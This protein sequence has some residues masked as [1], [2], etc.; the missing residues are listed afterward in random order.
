MVRENLTQSCVLP[1]TTDDGTLS[2]ASDR[3]NRGRS[4]LLHV[5]N[6]MTKSLTQ[7]R[8]WS[9]IKESLWLAIP[10]AIAQL[11]Q[12]ATAF[13]D[14]VMMGLLGS[15]II[16]AGALGATTFAMLLLIGSAIVSAVSPLVA[17]AF[18]AQ[19]P[20]RV[21][22][23]VRQGIWLALGLG[24]PVTLL[25]WNA[26]PILL[27]L[28]QDPDIVAIAEQYLR[29]IAWGYLP[30]LLFAVLRSFV[31][32]LSQTRP[33]IIIMASGTLFNIIANYVLM[34]GKLG[35]PAF[36][37]AGIGWASTLSFWGIF[38]ALLYYSL[39]Q[40]SIQFYRPFQRLHQFD[41]RIFGELLKVGLPIGVLTGVETGLFTVTTL[42]MGQLGT[43]SLAAHQI[44]LQTAAFTFTVPLGISFATTIRV[45]QLVGQAKPDTARLAGYI[46]MGLSFM[47]MSFMGLLFWVVPEAIVALY[48]DIHNP[49]NADVVTLAK[50]LLGV[51]AMF[52]IV[53]GIQ[54][55]AAGAL[56]GLKDTRIPMLIGILA[57]WGVGL[58]SGYWLGL[59][60]GLG[61]VG[62][63]WGLAIGLAVAAVVLA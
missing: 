21:G 6:G 55:A 51:A 52:Q 29:A 61:G 14:T 3:F 18:G 23:V 7:L 44:A 30:A 5:M 2:L 46:G 17:E 39:K 42:L 20:E 27:A 57:Y 32:A 22:R 9:E 37:L 50:S 36:G 49:I 10:L 25:I 33:I 12:A 53:D 1:L 35:I 41:Q 4:G 8:L 19:A 31:S 56:R 59:R 45:G 48:L 15:H 16:A 11:S 58:F 63:W 13:V 62:L 34:F 43:V 54:V 60:L 38:L 40:S 24:A 28:G 26:G 47:F